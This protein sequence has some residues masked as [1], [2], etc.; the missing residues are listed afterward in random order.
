[1]V[2]TLQK[3]FSFD[4]AGLIGRQWNSLRDFR[5]C[6]GRATSRYE[7]STEQQTSQHGAAINLDHLPAHPF[8]RPG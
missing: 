8:D 3:V 6:H 2:L 4:R 5:D 7:C 1:V